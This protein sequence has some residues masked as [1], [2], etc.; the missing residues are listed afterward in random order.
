PG[1]TVTAQLN[2]ASHL[3]HRAG[4]YVIYSDM[5]PPE[6]AYII[7]S[8]QV[9]PYPFESYAEIEKYLARQEQKGYLKVFDRSGWVVLKRPDI[10]PGAPP[11]LL[12][13]EGSTRAAA[14]NSLTFMKEPFSATTEYPMNHDGLTRITLFASNLDAEYEDAPG[15]IEVSAE[16]G[17]G[18]SYKMRVEAAYP[19]EGLVGMTQVNIRMPAELEAGGDVWVS[20]KA[21]GLTSNRA[22]INVQPDRH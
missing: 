7:A 5:P 20:I 22:L 13:E 8:S 18:R 2:I 19:V 1:A 6:T 4:A 17:Q 12:T 3:T 11:V 21:N 16:D 10:V 14:L 9:A 15:N